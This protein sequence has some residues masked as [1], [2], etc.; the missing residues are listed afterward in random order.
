MAR[1]C[2]Q[3]RVHGVLPDGRQLGY[4]LPD[5]VGEDEPPQLVGWD[6][7]PIAATARA[8]STVGKDV[9]RMLGTDAYFV[10]AFIENESEQVPPIGALP[11][12]FA[13]LTTL[14]L[15]S[16]Q[17][18]D[19]AIELGKAPVRLTAIGWRCRRCTCCSM[20]TAS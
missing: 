8:V 4:T 15:D 6:V 11:S 3:V 16:K 7:P 10:K 2:M 12:R 18:C 19:C 9:H 20:S 14:T 5:G 17:M 13:P 1:E